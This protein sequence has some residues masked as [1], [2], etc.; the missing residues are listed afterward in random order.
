M[1]FTTNTVFTYSLNQNPTISGFYPKKS[2]PVLKRLMNIT[3]QLFGSKANVYLTDNNGT[4]IYE[5]SIVFINN[6]LI[7]CVLGGGNTGIYRLKVVIDGKG[8]I[9]YSNKT[10]DYDIFQYKI[11][12]LSI[13]PTIGSVLG[14]TILSII[15]ENFSPNTGQNQIFLN[16]IICDII[17]N[18][19]TYINC[20]TRAI[21]YELNSTVTLYGRL[22]E[23]AICIDNT[24]LCLF[25]YSYK[26]TPYLTNLINISYKY[27]AGDKIG[28][29]GIL[30]TGDVFLYLNQ[31]QCAVIAHNDTYIALIIPDSL[32]IGLY[33]LT[34]RIANKGYVLHNNIMLNI[35]IKINEINVKISYKY[36]VYLTIKGSALRSSSDLKVILSGNDSNIAYCNIIEDIM[37]NLV[38]CDSLYV[39]ET[40][41]YKV[42][43]KYDDY[44]DY[45]SCSD[46]H[47]YVSRSNSS[48]WPMIY[49]MSNTEINEDLG[50][51]VKFKGFFNICQKIDILMYNEKNKSYIYVDGSNI[52][53]TDNQSL[54]FDFSR[55]LAINAAYRLKMNC[56]NNGFSSFIISNMSNIYDF[57]LIFIKY[58]PKITPILSLSSYI[59]GSNLYVALK[60]LNVKNLNRN[61]IR[62]CDIPVFV[63]YY[64]NSHG[65]FETPKI[66]TKNTINTFKIIEKTYMVNTRVL[67]FNDGYNQSFSSYFTDTTVSYR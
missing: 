19:N 6:T 49:S 66:L 44:I 58:I 41:D 11:S 50:E 36:G 4:N 29:I 35:S 47:F 65:I 20:T 55:I 10:N 42:I 56:F 39:N 37:Y 5:C 16:D 61:D 48:Q 13:Y 64:N 32:I 67:W 26:A 51:I 18:N 57:P 9:D 40:V 25:N 22:I 17:Y 38:K 60:G 52:Y 24:T 1:L 45:F 21:Q 15:G 43:V 30:L 2:S 46:C 59:G 34:I 28:F 33:N 8:I 3:G 53:K 63:R 62:V 23:K 54:I 31:I 7:S 27:Y 14:G 12:I